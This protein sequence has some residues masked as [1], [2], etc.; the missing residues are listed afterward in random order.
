[1]K[2]TPTVFSAGFA[3]AHSIGRLK[4]MNHVVG[5]PISLWPYTL[6]KGHEQRQW[7]RPYTLTK[8]F[9]ISLGRVEQLPLHQ[10]RGYG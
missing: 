10:Q 2:P 3:S 7:L 4:T 5:F 1:M 8:E 6:T 9:P